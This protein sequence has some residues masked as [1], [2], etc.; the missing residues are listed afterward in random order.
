MKNLIKKMLRKQIIDGQ[1]MDKAVETVCNKMVI[2]SYE[3][4][5]YYVKEALKQYDQQTQ[6]KLMQ[7][8]ITP[9]ENLKHEQIEI[10]D[11]IKKYHMSGD[12]LP[13]EAD[14]YWHQIQTI[15]CELGNN[16]Q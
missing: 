8:I 12:S 2:S 3:E 5:L 6:K 1:K 4:A 7:K 14:T 13:D 15:L 10:Y 16:G 9:L 11:E